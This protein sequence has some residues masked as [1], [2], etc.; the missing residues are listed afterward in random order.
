MRLP[1]CRV[2]GVATARA[3]TCPKM[4]VVGSSDY[5]RFCARRLLSQLLMLLLLG[6]LTLLLTPPF[7][8]ILRCISRPTSY[9]ALITK[10]SSVRCC[11]F[12]CSRF[13]LKTSTLLDSWTMVSTPFL[14][15]PK[16]AS[17]VQVCCI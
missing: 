3:S 12:M 5:R 7:V 14:L 13:L 8:T 1:R 6:P 17:P 4:V 11:C 10:R 9:N 15:N 2:K 16:G